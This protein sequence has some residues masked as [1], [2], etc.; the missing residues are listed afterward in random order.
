MYSNKIGHAGA[1]SIGDALAY[2]QSCHLKI[3]VFEYIHFVCNLGTPPDFFGLIMAFSRFI[4]IWFAAKTTRWIFFCSAATRLA[5]LALPR[6]VLP[7]RMSMSLLHLVN[8]FSFKN[9]CFFGA[10][11]FGLIMGF[12][13]VCLCLICSVNKALQYLDLGGN[14]IGDAGVVSIGGALAYVTFFPCE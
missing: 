1:A 7:W 4:C 13:K 11:R 9:I 6:S 2:I 12:I 10:I 3:S 8:E 5:M 14:Q